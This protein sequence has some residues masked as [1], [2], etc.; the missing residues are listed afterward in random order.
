MSKMTQTT[1]ALANIIRKRLNLFLDLI[2]K[3]NNKVSKDDLIAL[4]VNYLGDLKEE[5]KVGGCEA[6]RRTGDKQGQVCHEKISA[7]S[8]KYC[9]HHVNLESKKKGGCKAVFKSGEK[10]GFRCHAT[11]KSGEKYCGKHKANEKKEEVSE[12]EEEKFTTK[13]S[14]F[15]DKEGNRNMIL[16]IDKHR[17]VVDKKQ[18]VLGSEKVLDEDDKTCEV[19]DL[20]DKQKKLLKSKGLKY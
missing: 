14:E 11:V 10:E 15:K 9:Q 3:D 17:F 13:K 5:E 7:K 4:S 16:T 19:E 2:V 1:V 8:K 18:K 12:S 20:N 6:I